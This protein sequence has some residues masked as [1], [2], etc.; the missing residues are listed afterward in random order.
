MSDDLDISP[1]LSAEEWEA[2]REAVT[3][4]P[5][6]R[7]R[8][9]DL[10]ARDVDAEPLYPSLTPRQ[11]AAAM[12]HR[13]PFGFDWEDVD[14]IREIVRLFENSFLEDLNDYGN[15]VVVDRHLDTLRSLLARIPALLP[16]REG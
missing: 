12:L 14:R 8:L 1:A 5:V 11:V 16:P 15:H 10:L 9:M 4:T 2:V 13:Q 7:A 6:D 3:D